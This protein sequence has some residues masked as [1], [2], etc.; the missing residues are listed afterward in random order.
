MRDF[1]CNSHARFARMAASA[2][3]GFLTV[4]AWWV[5]SAAALEHLLGGYAGVRELVLGVILITSGP[6]LLGLANGGRG[7]A[8]A[9]AI[10]APSAAFFVSALLSILLGV[11]ESLRVSPPVDST[12]TLATVNIVAII[13]I[14]DLLTTKPAT[15]AARCLLLSV[16]ISLAAIML[17]ELLRNHV[18]AKFLCEADSLAES[19]CWLLILAYALVSAIG[20]NYFEN[21]CLV[22]GSYF[23]LRTVAMVVSAIVLISIVVSVC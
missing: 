23:S 6:L 1:V 3:A 20:V 17:L 8:L 22:N 10:L 15:T 21:I 9:A 4:S 13:A 18:L 19:S 16:P 7:R 11:L 2:L 5:L 12:I 14:T